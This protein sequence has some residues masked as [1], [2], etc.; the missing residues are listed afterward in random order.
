MLSLIINNT[1]EKHIKPKSL[2]FPAMLSLLVYY[3][4]GPS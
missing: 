4:H 3:E 2:H 1:N